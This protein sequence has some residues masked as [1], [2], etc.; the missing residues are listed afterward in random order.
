MNKFTVNI[1]SSCHQGVIVYPM[2]N[3]PDKY[4]SVN[5]DGRFLLPDSDSMWKRYPMEDTDGSLRFDGKFPDGQPT[6]WERFHR[7]VE[8]PTLVKPY[9][10]LEPDPNNVADYDASNPMVYNVTALTTGNTDTPVTMRKYTPLEPGYWKFFTDTMPLWKWR[11]HC[12]Y[13]KAP[14]DENGKPIGS[15][16]EPGKTTVCFLDAATSEVSLL[17]DMPDCAK[18][19]WVFTLQ[20]DDGNDQDVNAGSAVDVTHTRNY[21]PGTLRRCI[22]QRWQDRVL[23]AKVLPIHWK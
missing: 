13:F 21:Y 18:N 12:P 2:G 20:S 8:H 6:Q 3:I 17:G 16:V 5:S 9:Q 22:H 1:D 14:K 15:S 11:M 23:P 7:A 10:N 19:A 4:T